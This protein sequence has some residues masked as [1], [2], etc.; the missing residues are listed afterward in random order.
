MTIRRVIALQK[1]LN[2]LFVQK[3]DSS[4]PTMEIYKQLLIAERFLNKR[5]IIW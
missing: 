3:R 5:G 1:K 4:E 2:A